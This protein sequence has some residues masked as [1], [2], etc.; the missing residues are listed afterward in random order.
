MCDI[1]TTEDL[2]L[3]H[4]KLQYF[5][6]EYETLTSVM[7]PVATEADSPKETVE[8]E[9]KEG[10]NPASSHLEH[11]KIEEKQVEVE[12]CFSDNTPQSVGEVVD[13]SRT[14]IIETSPSPQELESTEAKR[15]KLF[16]DRA[17][18]LSP[19][20]EA[21][22]SRSAIIRHQPIVLRLISNLFIGATM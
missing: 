3:S 12:E 1:L 15:D 8:D 20:R 17:P 14:P 19:S 18:Q 22:S 5:R 16:G 13:A 2:S 6:T 21:R 7:I 10:E 4:L 9:S 11:E